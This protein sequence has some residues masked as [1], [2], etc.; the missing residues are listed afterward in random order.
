MS[1]GFLQ[2]YIALFL[3]MDTVSLNEYIE[4]VVP[5]CLFRPQKFSELKK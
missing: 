5:A 1:R 4:D 2:E 3:F